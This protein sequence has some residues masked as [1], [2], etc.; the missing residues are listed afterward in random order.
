M[1]PPI[2]ISAD[3]KATK[4]SLKKSLVEHMHEIPEPW[5]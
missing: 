4:Q 1:L 5:G 3:Y 2:Q